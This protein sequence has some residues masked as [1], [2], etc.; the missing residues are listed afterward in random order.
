MRIGIC[1]LFVLSV[2]LFVVN[3]Q[4]LQIA[5]NCTNINSGWKYSEK[6]AIDPSRIRD[7]SGWSV[8]DLPHTWNC[9]DATDVIPGY[10]RD[11][12]FYMKE[13][14]ISP[15]IKGNHYI[16][17]FEGSNITTRVF[18]NNK[19]A[20]DHVGG[21]VGFEVDITPFLQSGKNI[22]V[23]AVDNYYNPEIIPSSKSDFTIFGG[24]VRDVWLLQY[25]E[26]YLRKLIIKTPSV[27]A[28]MASTSVQVRLNKPPDGVFTL[29]TTVFDPNNIPVISKITKHKNSSDLLISLPVLKNPML[30]SPAT[31]FLYTV[32]TILTTDGGITDTISDR[33][34]YRWFE[35]KDYGSF[36]LNG[37]RFLIRG[38]HRHEDHAGYGAA[39]PN[40]IHRQDMK[41]IKDMGANFV[42]LAHYPQDPE[43]Y[44]T[45]DELG[46]LV[47]DELP[48]C[49]GA[50][51]GKVWKENTQR[52]L[53]EMIIQNINHPS[54]I[55]WSMGNEIDWQH[56]FVEY[57]NHDSITA[58]LNVINNQAHKLDPSRLTALR[59]YEPAE[60]IVDVYSPSIWS[61]W[62][63]GV[64]MDYEK[65]LTGAMKKYRHFLHMEYG[66]DSHVGRHN[67][68]PID[69]KG[70]IKTDNWSE[71]ENQSIVQSVS[72]IGDYSESYIVDLFDWHLKVSEEL[73]GFAGSAQ[74]SLKD[75]ATPLR[76]E[77]PIPYINQKGLMTRDGKP[78]DAYYVFRSYWDTVNPFVYIESHTWPLRFI[79]EGDS[80][81]LCVYSNM[82]SVYLWLN[83]IDAGGRKRRVGSFPAHGL[84]WKLNLEQGVYTV[85]AKGISGS[86]LVVTDTLH[87]TVTSAECRNP[88]NLQLTTRNLDDGS[89]LIEARIRDWKG[90]QCLTFN[91]TIYFVKESGSGELVASMGTPD[92]SQFIQMANGYACI[93]FIPEK[94]KRAVVS[95]LTNGVRSGYIVIDP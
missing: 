30:W 95:G 1:V 34:G 87:F 90:I 59:R 93:R 45:C 91:G 36:Y 12:G 10:T 7:F 56:D 37:E 78:K 71:S 73:P 9:M 89:I 40:F 74:W 27:N 47:W 19:F 86:S 17:Y 11:T 35:F 51:G 72:K 28:K 61:G 32:R 75:F 82:D 84:L 94:G 58:F 46:L 81:Q 41:A 83:G 24:I 65:A 52:L 60:R 42:R 20:G 8:I 39:L 77:N 18:V 92:G 5:G 13:L 76:P 15:V 21:Y 4:P 68:N 33:F 66:G 80:T 3:S 22:V 53:S 57:F 16:L 70:R 23:V 31:P 38:T 85:I 43:V 25:P 49:R 2:C 55:F 29:S 67:Q 6:K 14:I 88:D 54:V 48:W 26:V 63:A 64:Y 50:I 79:R 69:G 62:Y 44:K